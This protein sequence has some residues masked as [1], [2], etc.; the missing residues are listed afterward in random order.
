MD[1]SN[2][3]DTF[4]NTAKDCLKNLR[5]DDERLIFISPGI[6]STQIGINLRMAW[7]GQEFPLLM[8]DVDIVPTV[9]APWPQ[10]HPQPP[11]T[12]SDTNTVFISNTTR[13]VWRFSFGA[14][15]NH[16]MR[17]LSNCQRRVFLGCKLLLSS[18]KVSWWM[19]KETKRQFTFWD[20]KAFRLSVPAG[21]VLKNV[22]FEE[23]EDVQDA[24]LWTDDHLLD[25]MKSVFGRMCADHS[26]PKCQMPR[27]VMAYFGGDTQLPSFARGAP[28][29]LTFLRSLDAV[30]IQPS[31]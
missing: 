19:P 29:I 18:L 25:R 13:K 21:F 15:E 24:D 2:F 17:K 9:E 22:F 5:L 14:A 8:I 16:I 10:H 6:K 30:P 28:D 7:M 4:Y 3:I 12:P 11:L 27:K 26:D 31:S 1:G 23:L 20:K